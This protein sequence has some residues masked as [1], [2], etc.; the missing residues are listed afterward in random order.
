MKIRNFATWGLV[1]ASVLLLSTQHAVAADR[2]ASGKWIATWAA[3]PQGGFAGM[4][5]TVVDGQTLRQ[6]ARVSVGGSQLRLRLSNEYGST[7]LVIGAVSVGRPVDPATVVEGSLRTATFGGRKSI[8]VPPG[9][10]IFTDPIDYPVKAGEE[11]S[12][13]IYLPEK[14][15]G[16]TA[17]SLGLKTVIISPRGDFTT[18]T[19]LETA[20]KSES[21]FLVTAITASAAT[22]CCAMAPARTRGPVSTAMCW[23]CPASRM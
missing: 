6:R 22:S 12:I 11:I 8:T 3:S 1:L 20:S 4:A 9:A 2:A 10:P 23:R 7:P 14:V 15:E 5:G 21:M 19:K 18:Q 13:S 16:P 17:H